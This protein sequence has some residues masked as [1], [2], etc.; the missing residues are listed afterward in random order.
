VIS[1][2]S[3][4]KVPGQDPANSGRSKGIRKVGTAITDR[5][6]NKETMIP[7]EP[8]KQHHIKIY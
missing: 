4:N 1:R 7:V 5:A 2:S 3:I 8:R 6:V